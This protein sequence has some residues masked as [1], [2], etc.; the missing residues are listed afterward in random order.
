MGLGGVGGGG[1]I[2]CRI[3]KGRLARR[4]LDGG[5]IDRK[6]RDSADMNCLGSLNLQIEDG[7]EVQMTY[8]AGE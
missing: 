6:E 4:D 1:G 5:E 3:V 8:V 2:V 7:C